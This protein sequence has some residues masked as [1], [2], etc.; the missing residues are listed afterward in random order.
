MGSL[1][2]DNLFSP[3]GNYPF[4]I[5]DTTEQLSQMNWFEVPLVGRLVKIDRIYRRTVQHT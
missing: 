5:G 2:V 3:P 1:V 4:F